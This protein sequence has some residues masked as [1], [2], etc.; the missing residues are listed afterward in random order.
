MVCRLIEQK[1][2]SYGIRAFGRIVSQFPEAQLM[3]AGDG[4]MRVSL[5]AEVK[6]LKLE[7]RILFLGWRAHGVRLIAGFDIFLTPSLWKGFGLVML[8]A[9]AHSLPIIGSSDCNILHEHYK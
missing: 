9:M 2:I 1:G 6:A 4:Q 8:E 7:D 5:E 3:I